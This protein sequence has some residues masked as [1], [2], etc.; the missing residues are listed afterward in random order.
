[1]PPNYNYGCCRMSVHPSSSRDLVEDSKQIFFFPIRARPDQGGYLLGLSTQGPSLWTSAR[2]FSRHRRFKCRVKRCSDMEH[3]VYITPR[4]SNKCYEKHSTSILRLFG[5]KPV[6]LL[7]HGS[8]GHATVNLSQSGP[9]PGNW[10]VS[11]RSKIIARSYHSS[12]WNIKLTCFLYFSV[13]Y[14]FRDRPGSDNWELSKRS[15]ACHTY[16][17]VL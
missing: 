17:A 2:V 1:M 4:D 14:S 12:L 3:S 11:R 15:C 6:L 9:A 16:G 10:A 13:A 8:F 5:P 7:S